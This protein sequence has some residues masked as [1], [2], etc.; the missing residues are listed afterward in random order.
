[1]AAL[2]GNRRVVEQLRAVGVDQPGLAPADTLTAAGMAGDRVVASMIADDDPGSV[3]TAVTRR[4]DLVV[5][6]AALGRPDAV[7]LLAEIGFD[8]NAGARPGSGFQVGATAL[9]VAAGEGDEALVRLLLDLGAD[10]HACDA[11]FDGTPLDWA[12]HQGQPGTAD[13]LRP[14]TNGPG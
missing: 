4:P 8:V 6:A 13:L 3:D 5:T 14:L 11:A 2:N 1:M 9:H 12:V 10:P 7:S